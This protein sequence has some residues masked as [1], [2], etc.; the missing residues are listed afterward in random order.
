MVKNILFAK[1]CQLDRRPEEEEEENDDLMRIIIIIIIGKWI[2]SSLS[3][4]TVSPFPPIKGKNEEKWRN[5]EWKL[6]Q[7]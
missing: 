7:N 1:Y 3:L 4:Y 5:E 2:Q 6:T